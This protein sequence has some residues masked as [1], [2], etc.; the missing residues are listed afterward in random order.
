MNMRKAVALFAAVMMLATMLPISAFA[1]MSFDVTA[2]DGYYTVISN[3]EYSLAPGATESEIVVNNSE[4]SDRKVVHVFEVDPTEETIDVLPGYYGIDKIDPDNL[5][6]SSVWASKELSKTVAYYEDVLGY[7]VVGAMNTA[8]AYDSNAP[9]G[10]MVMNGVVLGDPTVHPG[11]QTYLA[12]NYDGTAELRAMTTPLT[13]NEKTAISANFGWLVKD[14]ALVGY[15][16]PER[17]SSDASRSMIGIKADGTLVFCQVDGRNAPFSTGLSN[18]EMGEMMLSLGC[19]NA[20]NC[21]GGGSSTFISKREGEEDSTM[22]SVPS[23]GSERPTINSVIIVSNAVPTGIFDHAVLDAAYDYYAAGSHTT[24]TMAG[25]DTNGYPVEVPADATWQLADSSFGTVENGQFVSSGKT[26][27][28]TVQLVYNG[29]VVGEKVLHVVHPEVFAFSVTDTVIPFGKSIS[30][31]FACTYG[32]DDWAVCMDGAY[33]LSLSDDTA[34]TLDGNTLTASSDESKS[35][36]V[37]TGVYTADPTVKATMNVTFG[38]GSEILFDF[39][40]N[41]LHGFVGFDEAKAWS[42][43]NGVDNTLVGADPLGGQ[44]SNEVDG[45]TWVASKENGGKVKNGD[46]ALAFTA[47]NT[48]ANFAQWTYNVLFNVEGPVVL[49]DVANGKNAVALGMWLYIPEGAAGMAFQSQFFTKTATGYNHVQTHFTFTTANGTEKNLNSCTEADIPE[50]RWVY[51]KVALTGNY[52]CTA[53]PTDTTSARSPSFLRTYVKPTSPMKLTF[54]IDDITLDYSSAV[55]DRVLPTISDLTYATADTALALENNAAISSNTLAF[56]ATIADNAALNY[57]TAT[58][59]VDGK[60]LDNVTA[61]GKTLSSGDV[62]LANGEHVVVFE[63]QDMLGNLARAE[64]KFTVGTGAA[65]SLGGHNDSGA[66]AEVDSIYYIDLKAEDMASVEKMTAVLKLQNANT[67]DLD[68]VQVA[69]GFEAELDYNANSELLYVELNRISTA[70]STFSLDTTLISIP[71][72]LWSWNAIDHFTGNEIAPDVHYATGNCPIVTIDCEV[73]EGEVVYAD[74]TA[75]SFGGSL[76]EATNINDTAAK[77]HTHTPEAIDDV[78]ATCI[79][80]GYEGRTYCADCGSIVETGTYLPATGHTFAIV[81]DQL[82]CH[83]GEAMTGIG[84]VELDGVTYYL[85]NGVLMSGWQYVDTDYYYFDT[86]T[87]EMATGVTVVDGMTYTFADDGKLVRGAFV[88]NVKGTMY[89]Y[90]GKLQARRFIELPEGTYW[91]KDNGY[92]AYGDAP[93]ILAS[94]APYIWYHFNETT[95]LLERTSDGYVEYDGNTYFCIDGEIFSDTA[96]KV[97]DDIICTTTMGRVLKNAKCWIAH[98]IGCDESEI[99]AG[100]HYCDADG[101]IVRTGF[102]TMDGYTYYYNDYVMAKGFTKVGEDYYFFNAA[103]GK[104]YK[105]TTLIVPK[106]DYGVEPGYHEFTAD[107]TMYV[108]DP[109]GP[110]AIIEKDGKL[111]FTIDGVVQKNILNELDGEYYLS[112][113]DGSLAVDGVYW[114]NNKNDLITETAYWFGFDADGKMIKDGF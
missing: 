9:Y 81:G 46:Y 103:S 64:R 73:V 48:M 53:D 63:V 58:I 54:F 31:E 97:G 78:E 84:L 56:S 1:A 69:P 36:V 14:G 15:T 44:C 71:V 51:A 111:Y 62:T 110:K 59:T 4:G 105:N 82:L 26:G 89:F 55:D 109:N 16:T 87:F 91:A 96:I 39:E 50:S 66:P 29:A 101:K 65:V 17:T 79:T 99:P 35:G 49:R 75:N 85:F 7:N 88:K 38:K 42:A 107:G 37:V 19:V 113:K 8:L 47:D 80:S 45:Y 5:S 27:D 114:V 83:C 3:N 32:V 112:Q 95:G 93:T 100:L 108:P 60:A 21:D 30:V 6:D 40:D 12:I 20:V 94:H 77:W 106:N 57:N 24:L 43:E 33:S 76:S 13:G 10:Y 67:W 68:A 34:A 102:A 11:A 104:M 25:V 61:S 92:I 74:K 22:R 28:A 98:Y 70:I 23:D 86:E 2:S 90:A 52:V 41:D 72:R 18:Y